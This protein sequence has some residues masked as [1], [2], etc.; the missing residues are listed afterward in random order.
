M[1]ERDGGRGDSISQDQQQNE[2]VE[3][4]RLQDAL[5]DRWSHTTRLVLID[6]YHTPAI[7]VAAENLGGGRQT[8]VKGSG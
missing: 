8:R 5:E 1:V 2:N 4:C 6:G 7:S 3:P